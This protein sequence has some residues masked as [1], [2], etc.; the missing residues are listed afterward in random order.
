MIFLHTEKEPVHDY[1]RQAH[2]MF[3]KYTHCFSC[4]LELLTIL[5][6]NANHYNCKG[7]MSYEI[8]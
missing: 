6:V 3:P 1:V 2:Y 4:L 8:F 7:A 5:L